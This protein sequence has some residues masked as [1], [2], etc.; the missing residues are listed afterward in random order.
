L[1]FHGT[2][3]ED[4]IMDQSRPKD[5]KGGHLG[6]ID[7]IIESAHHALLDLGLHFHL[8]H[9]HP[10]S[11]APFN[12]DLELRI[13]DAGSVSTLPFP[14]RQT[15][16]AVWINADLG[17]RLE[18]QPVAWRVWQHARSPQSHRSPVEINDKSGLLHTHG[19]IPKRE[20][21]RPLSHPNSTNLYPIQI[22]NRCESQRG[23]PQVEPKS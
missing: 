7:Q 1:L 21:E 10:I 18:I 16:S 17:T 4:A 15:N 13:I 20:I 19:P 8:S 9:W 14:C 6:S 11:I 22:A 3:G 5:P 2:I 12:Q 23:C